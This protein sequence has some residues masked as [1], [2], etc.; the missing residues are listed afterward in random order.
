MRKALQEFGPLTAA[1]PDGIEPIMLLKAWDSIK[2]AFVSIAKA[3]FLLGYR[4]DPW[5]NSLG[6]FLP[7][8]GKDNYYNPE[9]YRTI[10]LALVPLKWMEREI[11]WHME[12]DLKIY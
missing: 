1:G 9:S 3:S 8:P 11:L 2:Q 12:V 5:R 6:I 7:K 4:P 10:T